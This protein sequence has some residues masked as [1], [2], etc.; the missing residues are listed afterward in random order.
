MASVTEN[1]AKWTDLI[2]APVHAV[3]LNNVD[4]RAVKQVDEDNVRVLIVANHML[5]VEMQKATRALE[6][7]WGDES[8]DDAC[9]DCTKQEVAIS[10]DNGPKLSLTSIFLPN[11]PRVNTHDPGESAPPDLKALVPK[12]WRLNSAQTEAGN[13]PVA[14]PL[15]L[16]CLVLLV[17]AKREQLLQ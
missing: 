2:D 12:D 16:L 17:R 15:Y 6:E 1:S 13:Y 8:F 4:V 3:L 10:S 7:Y 14:Y 9:R 5:Q 11:T